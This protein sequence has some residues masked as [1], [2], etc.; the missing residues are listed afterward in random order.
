MRGFIAFK[1][2]T[3]KCVQFLI[4][5]I[6]NKLEFI[7][8]WYFLVLPHYELIRI[9]TATVRRTLSLS[10]WWGSLSVSHAGLVFRYLGIWAAVAAHVLL[11]DLHHLSQRV[12]GLWLLTWGLT[13]KNCSS[14]SDL[15]WLSLSPVLP[16]VFSPYV[17]QNTLLC[18]YGKHISAGNT[19]SNLICHVCSL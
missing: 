10:V 15:R 16:H 1:L 5:F 7:R 2:G 19:N 4:I 12:I 8:F 9:L 13:Q 14:D 17:R 11:W 18:L 6:Y 3:N